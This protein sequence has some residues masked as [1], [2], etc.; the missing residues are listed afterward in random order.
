MVD[1]VAMALCDAAGRSVY[2]DPDKQNA[3]CSCC[4]T[5]PD[6]RR[7]CIYWTTFRGEART[8]IVAAYAWHKENRRW[9]SWLK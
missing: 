7:R 1:Q 8:A 4:E 3:G 6:G 9:P 5:L 2:D